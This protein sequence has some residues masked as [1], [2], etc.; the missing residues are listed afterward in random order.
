MGKGDICL[1]LDVENKNGGC[2]RDGGP[3]LVNMWQS[4][5]ALLLLPVRGGIYLH[6]RWPMTSPLLIRA[7][8]GCL[9][10]ASS[11]LTNQRRSLLDPAVLRSDW[12]LGLES[13]IWAS[14]RSPL[15]VFHKLLPLVNVVA[16]P[17]SV[18]VTGGSNDTPTRVLWSQF[19]NT[20]QETLLLAFICL[21]L[22][23]VVARMEVTRRRLGWWA[24]SEA[25]KQ[26][27]EGVTVLLLLSTRFC[28]RYKLL[29]GAEGELWE[30]NA[31][32]TLP[33]LGA[34]SPF[35]NGSQTAKGN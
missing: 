28:F 35:L 7:S 8:S 4:L 22:R 34:V 18:S 11:S 17:P 5:M 21:L 2:R 19:A 29:L 25:R 23:V 10:S 33:G 16:P 26:P 13:R 14:V 9:V 15:T 27:S 24:G 3:H 31:Q 1:F 30:R 32:L 20:N 6:A 12:W